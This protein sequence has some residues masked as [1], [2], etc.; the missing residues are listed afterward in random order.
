MEKK[1]PFCYNSII[2]F[3]CWTYFRT[4]IISAYPELNN[5]YANHMND[6]Y[7]TSN[8]A[9]DFGEHGAKYN[10]ISH[11]AQ[12]LDFKE[13]TFDDLHQETIVDEIRDNIDNGFYTIIDIEGSKAYDYVESPGVFQF[14]IY[15]YDSKKRVFFGPSIFGGTWHESEVEWN[16]FVAAFNVRKAY[17]REKAI[18]SA[19]RQ[20]PFPYI[21][22]KP[23]LNDAISPYLSLF[24]NEIRSTLSFSNKVCTYENSKLSYRQGIVAVY[25]GLSDL[26]ECV[27]KDKTLPQRMEYDHGLLSG[28][29]KVKEYNVLFYNRIKLF[30][31]RFSL[32][33]PEAVYEQMFKVIKSN[34]ITLSYI[35]KY[36]STEQET[37]LRNIVKRLAYEKTLHEKVLQTLM[38]TLIEK[39]C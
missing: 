25:Q 38:C 17:S 3:E 2:K 34:G 19:A 18:A 22:I 39:V 20:N 31:K 5:W 14:L 12:A 24:F 11:Y 4:S 27:M 36:I 1:L 35:I 8:F 13:S 15:G 29:A 9:C 37:I 23:R 26:I 16:H 30:D 28:F 6:I 21:L 32:S 33:I 10:T 7:I